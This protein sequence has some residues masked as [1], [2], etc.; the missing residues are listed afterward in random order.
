MVQYKK[1]IEDN[2]TTLLQQFSTVTYISLL[3]LHYN[4]V[5]GQY[6]KNLRLK[7][8][9]TFFLFW[10]EHTSCCLYHFTVCLWYLCSQSAFQ[11]MAWHFNFLVIDIIL[12]HA[13]TP[14]TLVQRKNME[15]KTTHFAENPLIIVWFSQTLLCQMFLWL[16]WQILL[17]FHTPARFESINLIGSRNFC[18]WFTLHNHCGALR[19]CNWEN[20]LKICIML[21]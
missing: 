21:A 3:I 5:A 2:C 20:S 4:G 6:P 18:F 11:E 1:T 10:K 9:V 17:I 13:K 7:S 16:Y 14:Q 15:A 8:I 19:D 12:Y